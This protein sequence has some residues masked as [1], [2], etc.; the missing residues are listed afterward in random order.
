MRLEELTPGKFKASVA[1]SKSYDVTIERCPNGAVKYGCNCPYWN[2]PLCKHVVAVLLSIDAGE[3]EKKDGA[4]SPGEELDPLSEEALGALPASRLARLLFELASDYPETVNWLRAKLSERKDDIR[5]YRDLIQDGIIS[6]MEH[7]YVPFDRV[8]DALRG[9]WAAVDHLDE[10]AREGDYEH[11]LEFAEMI[12]TEVSKLSEC[13][14]EEGDVDGVI[15]Q[16][17]NWS[18]VTYENRICNESEAVQTKFF[19]YLIEWIRNSEML[20][21]WMPDCNPI[22]ICIRIADTIPALRDEVM[23]FYGDKMNI[24]DSHSDGVWDCSLESAQS[25]YQSLLLQW[26]GKEAAI[27]FAHEHLNNDSL[28][29]FLFE[30]ALEKE[31]YQEALSLCGQAEDR[32]QGLSHLYTVKEWKHRRYEVYQRMGL[33]AEQR[34]L[35][36]ELLL[37]GETEYYKKLERLYTAQQWRQKR[38]ELLESLKI[39]RYANTTYINVIIDDG[40]KPRILDYVREYPDN[41]FSLYQYLLPEY[42]NEVKELF[43]VVLRRNAENASDRTGYRGVCW[44][45]YSYCQVC[46]TEN[47]AA[48]IAELRMAYPR[49]RAFQD[50]LRKIT[51]K[52]NEG[53]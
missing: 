15:E 49:R 39:S 38:Q 37:S 32:A 16:C 11:T 6:Q 48:I 40:D 53:K 34:A 36:E 17:M 1:G 41:I 10:L 28:C 2:A 33:E 35:G 4:Q 24:D 46:G 27:Q 21:W 29:K 20:D 22:D 7:G 23:D 8:Y 43:R 26:K 13:S 30:N 44:Q 47:A 14:E 3:Y 25:A 19:H 5:A 42:E 50:E 12:I 18:K 31:H 51:Q 45:I 52:I 9:A